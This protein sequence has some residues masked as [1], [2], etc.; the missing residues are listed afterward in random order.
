MKM[1]KMDYRFDV[2]QEEMKLQLHQ[3]NRMMNKMAELVKVEPQP[4][5]VVLNVPHSKDKRIKNMSVNQRKT[6][7][8]STKRSKKR[9]RRKKRR[10]SVS[11]VVSLTRSEKSKQLSVPG[12][13]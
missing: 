7:Q 1:R 11:S 5:I 6:T 9:K 8:K 3:Q 10:K 4:T 13:K 12:T 2:L